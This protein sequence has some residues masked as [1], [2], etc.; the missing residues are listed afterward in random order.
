[1]KIKKELPLIAIVLLPVIYLAIIWNKL[2]DRVPM[3]WSIGG[4]VDRYGSRTELL[5]ISIL[6]PM[7]LYILLLVVPQIDP[8]KNLNKMG[9]KYQFFRLIFTALISGLSL[10][11][12]Y[13]AK[14][15][16]AKPQYIVLII[17]V[18]YAILGNY[19]QTIKPNY[20]IGIRTPWTLENEA[21]WRTTHR[22]AGILWFI[23]GIIVVLLCL[24]LEPTPVFVSFLIVTGLLVII[25]MVYSYVLFRRSKRTAQ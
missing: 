16:T 9:N 17:G 21:V 15:E 3:H 2:P 24:L 13:A 7:V 5:L 18:S 1:M 20:F 8:K 6:L 25:P 10:F 4:E 19:F 12:L 22:L 14:S 11:I 23:G